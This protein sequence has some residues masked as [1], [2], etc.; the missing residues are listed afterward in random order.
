MKALFLGFKNQID[1]DTAKYDEVCK[2]RAESGRQGGIKKAEKSLKEYI[3]AYQPDIVIFMR[4]YES[5]LAFDGN[6]I[7]AHYE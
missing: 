7:Y 6:G 2:K 4:D 5:L 3:E 1:R